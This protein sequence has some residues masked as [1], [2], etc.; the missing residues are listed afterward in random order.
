MGDRLQ[1]IPATAKRAE[2]I[3]FEVKVVRGASTAGEMINV[4]LKVCVS[5]CSCVRPPMCASVGKEGT[6]EHAH[7]PVGQ[8]LGSSC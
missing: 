6:C 7:R 4:D 2:G 5:V 1:L 3:N 8:R